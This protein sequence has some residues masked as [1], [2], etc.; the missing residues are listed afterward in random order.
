MAS[1]PDVFFK[2]FV[3]RRSNLAPM[4][5]QRRIML[6]VMGLAIGGLLAWRFYGERLTTADW[7]PEQRVKMRLSATLIAARPQ[8][9]EQ[10]EQ[11]PAIL[12]D[13]RSA[14]PEASVDFG[15]SR[16]TPDSIYYSVRAEV[17]GRMADLTIAVTRDID[18]DT[19]AT[20]WNLVER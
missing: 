19:T 8:A 4:P 20:L 14:M 17:N 10:L 1:R 16:R 15:A 9:R 11:W 18:S 2:N 6:Y 3:A 13:V 7:L 12:A 5:L